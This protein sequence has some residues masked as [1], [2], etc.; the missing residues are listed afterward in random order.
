MAR[1]Y[2]T[3]FAPPPAVGQAGEDG[4]QRAEDVAH[5]GHED[6]VRERHVQIGAD[7][8]SDRAA[9]VQLVVEHDRR[10]DHDGQVEGAR[11]VRG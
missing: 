7:L 2:T 4:G 8:G 10:D 1:P 5:N 6:Q 9:D 11:A 3:R